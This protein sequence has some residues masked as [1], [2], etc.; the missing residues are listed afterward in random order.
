MDDG[1]PVG[2]P[3]TV[4]YT[5]DDD[6]LRA[7]FEKET[8]EFLS[9]IDGVKGI[10]T[11]NVK[12]K[13]E[14]RLKLDYDQMAKLGLTALDVSRTVRAAF[15]GEVVTSIRKGGEEIDFRVSLADPKKYRAEGVLDLSI[16]NSMGKLVPLGSFARFDETAGPSVIRHYDGNRSVTVTAEV[17]TDRITSIEANELVRKEFMPKAHKH[18]GFKMEIGGEEKKTMESMQSFFMALVM[19]CVAIYFLLVIL[20]NSY[21]KPILIMSAIPFALIGVFL[22]FMIHG[23]PLSFIALIGILGLVGVVVNDTIVMVSHLG[24]V[25]ERFGATFTTIGRGAADRFRPVILTTLTTTAGLMPIAYG[26]GGDLP[27]IRPMVLALAWGLVFA[28]LISLI[29]IPLVYSLY[30][31]AGNE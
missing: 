12:G 27:F 24:K 28:T 18:A 8:M 4:I 29:F 1:P 7:K 10:E 9:G 2:K 13:D 17:D 26:I 15:E 6:E 5:S 11:T 23:L 14:L 25:C 19:A 20:F 22:T 16:A 30:V 21:V 3:I 31:R